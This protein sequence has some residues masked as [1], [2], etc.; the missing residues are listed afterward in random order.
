[1][2]EKSLSWAVIILSILLVIESTIINSTGGKLD[3]KTIELERR[4]LI[5]ETKMAIHERI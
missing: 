4:V 1:M 5:L 3:A 2:M